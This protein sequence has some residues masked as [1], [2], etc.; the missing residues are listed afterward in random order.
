MTLLA[1]RGID[2]PARRERLATWADGS[3]L[4]LT[5]GASLLPIA[6]QGDL[7]AEL[8]RRLTGWLAG[9]PTLD[10]DPDVLAVAALTRTVDARLLA[11]ALPGRPTRDALQQLGQLRVTQRL[12]GGV[13][14][15]P[16]LAATIKARLKEESPAHYR[17]LAGRIVEHLATRARLGD[18]EA[19]LEMTLFIDSAQLRAVIGMEASPTHYADRPRQGEIAQ[20]ARA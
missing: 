9:E 14:L 5:V 8:E 10:I 19:L 17:A 20:F 4:A 16:V 15:H 1:D 3:P 13:S 18:I 2:D 12:A 6:A 7:T 11:A